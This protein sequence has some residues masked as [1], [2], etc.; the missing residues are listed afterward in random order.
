M[1]GKNVIVVGGGAAG[2]AAARQLRADGHSPTVLE[3]SDRMG[4]RMAGELIDGFSLEVG[5][6]FSDSTYVEAIKIIEE[7]GLPVV[8]APQDSAVNIYS[9]R[10]QKAFTSSQFKKT[11]P[12]SVRSF[13]KLVSLGGIWELLKLGK[14]LRKRKDDFKS[15]DHN[16]LL[17]LDLEG[18]FSDWLHENFGERFREGACDTCRRC[19]YLELA[20]ANFAAPWHDAFLGALLRQQGQPCRSRCWNRPFRADVCRGKQ[21]LLSSLDSGRGDCD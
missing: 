12:S 13:F 8:P 6:Q 17:D 19:R 16:R 14:Y 10:R 21:E 2:L 3:A 11:S 7:L 15:T 1:S 18:S 4:G 9:A 5:A 20:G